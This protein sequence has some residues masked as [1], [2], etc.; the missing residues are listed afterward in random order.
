MKKEFSK[1]FI[2]ND[3]ASWVN[4]NE[5]RRLVAA[6]SY[7]VK[8]RIEGWFSPFLRCLWGNGLCLPRC[9]LQCFRKMG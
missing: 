6:I 9:C 5:E 2:P 8:A 1:Y 4:S 7:R 3:E